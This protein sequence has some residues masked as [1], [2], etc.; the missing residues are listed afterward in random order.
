MKKIVLTGGPGGGKT[1]ALDL[2]SRE[3]Q[4]Q[5]AVVPEA[6]TMMFSGGVSRLQA[7][8]YPNE[9]QVAIY[10]LQRNLE[11]LIRKMC[12][13]KTLLCDRGGLDGIAYWSD[14][15]D[16]FLNGIKSTIEKEIARYDAVIFFETAARVGGNIQTNN[17]IRDENNEKAIEIDYKLQE[18]W[19]QHPHFILVKSR[20][21]FLAKVSEGLGVI[22]KV[23]DTK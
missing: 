5:V 7:K 6:A 12:P 23:M 10:R 1:T 4:G 9:T 11:D 22:K 19:S 13:N 14:S 2:F 8:H 18:V 20:S 17:P 16:T 15:Q 21:S 3:F